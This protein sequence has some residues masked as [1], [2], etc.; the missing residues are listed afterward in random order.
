MC[1]IMSDLSDVQNALRERYGHIHPLLFFRSL[2][3]AETD[4]ELFDLLH[5]MPNEF[6]LIWNEQDKKWNVTNDLLQSNGED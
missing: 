6:P 2:E 4:G 3:R 1:D 5:D